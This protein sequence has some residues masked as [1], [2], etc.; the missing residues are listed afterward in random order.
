M[1]DSG[2]VNV[3]GDG[4]INGLAIGLNIGTINQT[5]HS[6]QRE[7]VKLP[8]IDPVAAQA[9]LATLPLDLIPDP[10]TMLPPGSR[11]LLRHNDQ[12]VGRDDDLKRLAAA[13]KGNR[14]AAIT[15]GIGGI[16]KTQLVAEFAHRYGQFFAGGV[17]W[18]SFADPTG[19]DGEIAACGGAGALE[20]YTD[21]DGLK[22]VEQVQRVY[23]AWA[24]ET[25]RLLIFDNCDD[26][27]SVTAEKLLAD[28]LP[29]SG[30]CWI[31]VTSRRGLWSKGLRLATLALDV[32]SRESSIAL[33]RS[34][35]EDLSHD[36]A[37]A[38]AD[39]VGALPLALTL[40]GSY[41]A[42]YRK[43]AFGIPATYLENL[44]KQLLDHR[45]MQGAGESVSHTDH[46]L[47]VRTTFALSYE[48]LNKD[49]PTDALAIA[50]LARAACLASGEPFP[51]ELL[52]TLGEATEDEKE[53]AQQADALRR[54]VALGL[55]EGAADGTLRIHRLISAFASEEIMA[56]EAQA[57]V[58][59]TLLYIARGVNAEGYPEGMRPIIV[60]L[61]YATDK[62]FVR[63]D[64][65]ASD[66][67]SVLSKH[68]QLIAD[69]TG[70]RPYCERALAIREQVLGANHLL[71]AISLNDL[72]ELYREQGAYTDAL[73]LLQCA[74]AI[75]TQVLGDN[76][77]YIATIL[78]NLAGVYCAQGAY[79]DAL[80]LL[81][82][83]ITIHEQ[84]PGGNHTDIAQSLNNLAEL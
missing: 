25:P 52:A 15:T 84:V 56:V 48:R 32:L 59:D 37:D 41:L 43:D 13:I 60:H 64:E 17:F 20:L 23:A 47:S 21:A 45:S 71:T 9:L 40:A 69:Y 7:R 29:R 26:Q 53:A 75:L 46:D 77:P 57:A 5:I 63:D 11:M 82:R 30:G 33:L 18:L 66:L 50:A 83:A 1:S 51:R 10:T 8:L 22:Q 12:F 6:P 4:E 76:H 44:H 78:N 24:Q 67:C 72:A 49:I 70:A 16:G 2:T 54:L 65:Q 28:R 79:T 74:L 14:T 68:L 58:E 35:R 62:A 27:A 61:R 19:I 80:P 73:P 31:L 42:T 3:S 34:Y 55:L 39:E 81:Q 38:I 36:D